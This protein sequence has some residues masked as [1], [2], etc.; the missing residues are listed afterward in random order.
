MRLLN[1]HI[2]PYFESF[3]AIESSVFSASFEAM[4]NSDKQDLYDLLRYVDKILESRKFQL[5]KDLTPIH[6]HIQDDLENEKKAVLLE[7]LICRNHFMQLESNLDDSVNDTL[8]A[9]IIALQNQV[10]NPLYFGA[11]DGKV[12]QNKIRKERNRN[13]KHL[14]FYKSLRA[15]TSFNH[16]TIFNLQVN[17]LN[18]V[19]NYFTNQPITG[20]VEDSKLVHNILNTTHTL[21]SIDNINT[22]LI[23]LSKSIYL[24][25]CDRK[26]LM[27]G[28]SVT[29]ILKWN[30]DYD[31][32][33]NDYVIVSFG[34]G[35]RSYHSL[36][37]KLKSVNEKYVIPVDATYTLHNYELNALLKAKPS[38]SIDVRFVGIADSI[39]LEDFYLR[40]NLFEIY[41]LRSIRLLNIY[42]LCFSEKTK[43]YII[44]NI[45]SLNTV[46]DLLSFATKQA[47][48]ELPEDDIEA[49]KDTLTV[50]LDVVIYSEYKTSI[51]K[52]ILDNEVKVIVI[53]ESIIKNKSLVQ[54]LKQDLRLDSNVMLKSWSDVEEI[55]SQNIVIL[56]YRDQGRFTMNFYPNIFELKRNNRFIEAIFM[57]FMFSRLFH[58]S[59]YNLKKDYHKALEHP[60]R[61]EFFG[62]KQLQNAI[63]LQKPA[64]KPQI[65]WKLE[66]EYSSSESREIF[67]LQIEDHRPL[68]C[69]SAD[70]FIMLVNNNYK[71]VKSDD[72]LSLDLNDSTD[73]YIQKLDD[74]L[75]NINLYDTIVDSAE[76]E[77]E[78]RIMKQQYDFDDDDAGRLWKMLLQ[79]KSDEMGLNVLYEE[80][81][82]R[83][84]M[85]K[86]KLVSFSYFKN[87]WINPQS[88]SLAPLSNMVFIELCRYLEIPKVYFFLIQRIRNASKQSSRQSTRKMHNLL[89]DLFN[90]GCFDED[91]DTIGLISEKLPHYKSSHPLD[92][93][94]INADVLAENLVVLTELI[95]SELQLHKLEAIG[96]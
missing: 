43:A 50:L 85:K 90:D 2:E 45:F 13:K 53:D 96:R 57:K 49:I 39:A 28:F 66:H 14:K 9:T 70:L 3:L 10:S 20:G 59:K 38:D 30:R 91:K 44:E 55:D 27:S 95:K 83:F 36:I 32:S 40:I 64:S 15:T 33:F 51:Q 41:E 31:T 92:D 67:K 35:V 22:E 60:I 78:L 75:E 16:K 93:I 8:N 88:E 11:S 18:V 79:Q 72:L 6:I 7:F 65:N 46:S 34:S 26:H 1:K 74:I 68:T 12:K 73:Y 29:E 62:W 21:S 52:C 71:V 5:E 23:D 56:S 89:S 37:T 94:G 48:L 47:L 63:W 80:L 69:Y 87:T 81:N 4:Q 42:A 86:L 76:Q 17:M 61:N 82:Y 54:L 25:D 19:E 58:W 24:F 77:K 84:E